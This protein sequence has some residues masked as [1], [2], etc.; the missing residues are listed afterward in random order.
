[1]RQVLDSGAIGEVQRV[2]GAFTF[3]MRPLN[4][5]NIR[6]KASLAG[7]SL[8][9]VGCYPVYAIRWAF[10]AEPVRVYAA[11]RYQYGVD[12]EM[13]GLVWL[14]DGRVGAFDSGFTLPLRGWLEITGVDGTIFIPD[15]WQPGPR[16]TFA[17]KRIGKPMEE[18]AIEGEDQI[19]HMI[20]H[21]SRSIL[22]GE[23]PRPS[24]R[25]AVST[26]RVLDALALSAR[27]EREIDV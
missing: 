5:D 21:F 16:A 23:T 8:L 20:D 25:E 6:L 26:L 10:G 9:D 7:G 11:A 4:P 1:V 13:N 14:A 17:I 2:A 18:E 3:P 24:P 27:E 19:V 12:V 15:L 22:Q